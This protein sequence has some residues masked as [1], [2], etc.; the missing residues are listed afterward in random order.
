MN[1][2]TKNIV[3]ISGIAISIIVSLVVVR[4]GF[5]WTS[6]T[7]N[8][9]FAN[10]SILTNGGS[11]GFGGAPDVSTKVDIVAT[12]DGAGLLRLSTERPW[13][14]RQTSTGASAELDLHSTVS[15]KVFKVT[16][17][18]GNRAAQFTISDTAGNNRVIMVPDGGNV[19]IG[20]AAPDTNYKITTSGGGIKAENSSATQP[21]GYFNNAGGGPAITAGTGG[22]TL[23]GV[24]RTS[25]PAAGVG[26]SGTTNYVPKFTAGTTLGN[27]QIFDNGTNVG[28]GTA[29]PG[30]KFTVRVVEGDSNSVANGIGVI[31]DT[32]GKI[33]A[34][35][36]N[37]GYGWIQSHGSVP[38]YIN[39]LGNN[40]I[41]NRAGGNV[42]I[43]IAAPI[44]KAHIYE[45]TTNVGSSAGLTV[46]QASTGDAI[47]QYLLTGVQ[48]WT[49]GVDNSDA[50]K[51]KIGRGADWVTGVDLAINTTGNISIGTSTPDT[52]YKITTSGG[53]I[54]AENASATQPAGY[55][56]TTGGGPAITAGTGGITLGGVNR[57]SWPSS[58]VGGSGTTNY[59]PK[60]TAGTT[61]GNSQLFDNGTNVG[62]GTTTP[63]AKLH[64]LSASGYSILENTTSGTTGGLQLK[65]AAVS[66][67]IGTNG[68]KV[69][70][71]AGDGTTEDVTILNNG[72]VGIGT[73][74]PYAKLSVSGSVI[75]DRGTI[76]NALVRC[77]G[78]VTFNASDFDCNSPQVTGMAGGVLTTVPLLWSATDATLPMAC[79]ALGGTAAGVSSSPFGDD[80]RF[81]FNGTSWVP[82]YGR[83]VS[84]LK[85]TY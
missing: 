8:P 61:L 18:N 74:T 38:L 81:G 83:L 31:G 4:Q 40:V 76:G 84:V 68:S 3:Q 65:N 46:E 57:T 16:S 67:Y 30:S 53:G 48:R 60:F 12:G 70:V 82:V 75:D 20:T 50:D 45:S 25:W 37:S 26:G 32:N 22:I 64:V 59:L 72:N 13:I 85:C 27:S 63:S 36:V 44:S 55:F 69:Y 14:F 6:P 19:G 42:G 78:G 15:D 21:A 29:A 71:Y 43:G 41:L 47:I 58:G 9:P 5:A 54:K 1:M 39:E 51:F 24:N 34:I 11:V 33:V 66:S 2:R 7:G 23:G 62:I 28:V 80:M 49:M 35:G 10:P 17:V 73:I 56:S 77:S 79:L 52:N